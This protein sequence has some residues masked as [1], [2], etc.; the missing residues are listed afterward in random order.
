MN[1]KQKKIELP[2][3]LSFDRKLEISDA[4]M[5]SG[6]MS[7]KDRSNF[8]IKEN[9]KIVYW[10]PIEIKTRK[11]RGTISSQ[12]TSEVDMLKPNPKF[13][14]NDGAN[15]LMI[16]NTLKIAFSMRII[17]NLGVPFA[18]NKPV[19]GGAI[20][21]KV[22]EV[23]QDDSGVIDTLAFRYAYNIANGRFL[24]RN[25]VGAENI[26]IKVDCNSND[27]K[28]ELT[29]TSYKFSINEFN[30]NKEDSDLQKLTQVIKTGLLAM[31]D[32]QFSYIKVQAFVRLENG[33]QIF[34]SE[35]MNMGEDKKTLCQREG[36]AAIHDVKIG[37]AIKTIDTWY[38]DTILVA[39]G[40][41][42]KTEELSI[43]DED[44]RP[45]AIE[46]FGSVTQ[47]GTAFRHKTTDF[48]SLLLKWVNRE[49]LTSDDK[50]YVVGNL[51]RGGVFSRKSTK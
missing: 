33:Q 18:C 34:P 27:L 16:D 9:K 2:S 35:E 10:N 14:D 4:L 45:I 47:R 22:A 44:K 46:P 39:K 36:C 51:I 42:K 15:L 40:D 8:E 21:E 41:D 13:S 6:T 31:G 32:D 49:E 17:G 7:D 37:N 23:K 38:G 5:Y 26:F 11:N 20:I 50:T 29:F 30:K 24:W 12:G 25:R 43:K 28:E 3:L 19:F 1:D 48:Y